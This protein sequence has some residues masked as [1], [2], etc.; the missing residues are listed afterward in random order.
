MTLSVKLDFTQIGLHVIDF[1]KNLF[2]VFLI[3]ISVSL[4]GRD[5]VIRDKLY[6]SQRYLTKVLMT[7]KLKKLFKII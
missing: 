6:G 3:H 4:F 7:Y 2:Q 5:T 1:I